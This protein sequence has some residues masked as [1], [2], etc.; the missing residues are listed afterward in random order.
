MENLNYLKNEQWVISF[1]SLRIQ[2]LLENIQNGVVVGG[3]SN[4]V[5]L[6]DALS[7]IENSVKNIKEYLEIS[8]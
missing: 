6:E 4:E 5:Q 2:Q 8:I 3:V 7:I 1:N